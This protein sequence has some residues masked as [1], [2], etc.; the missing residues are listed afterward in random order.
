MII[1]TFKH[2]RIE[3]D[4]FVIWINQHTFNI[5][6]PLLTW[7]KIQRGLFFQTAF[8]WS[9]RKSWDYGYAAVMRILGFGIGWA[10]N[11]CENPHYIEDLYEVKK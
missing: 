5:Y 11:H 10:Y 8:I 6:W 9:S 3:S 2:C 7:S 4:A 1:K